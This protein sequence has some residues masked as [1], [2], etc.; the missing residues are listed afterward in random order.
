MKRK[1]S[2][3][4][5]KQIRKAI[6]V[7]PEVQSYSGFIQ[8]SLALPEPC[9]AETRAFADTMIAGLR[10]VKCLAT[11]SFILSFSCYEVSEKSY[12]VLTKVPI[13]T[14]CIRIYAQKDNK[15]PVNLYL[16][17]KNVLRAVGKWFQL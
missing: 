1:I 14:P 15:K 3:M 11:I 16:R 8:V 9:D 13:A 12:E 4:E 5:L 2:R 17:F 6:E 7:L 10:K